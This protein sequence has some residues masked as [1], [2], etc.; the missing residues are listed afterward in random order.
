MQVTKT[1]FMLMAK[2]MDRALAFY[3]DALGLGELFSSPDWSELRAGGAV[4]ALHGGGDGT[5]TRTGLGFEVD[6]LAAACTAVT[7]AGGT[8]LM[9]PADRAEERIRL[10]EVQDPEGNSFSLAEPA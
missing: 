6:D 5:P 1:Y 2:D 4:V 9:P 10:A 3:R 8:I 7:D